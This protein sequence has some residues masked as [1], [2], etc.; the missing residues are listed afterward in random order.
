M[1][2][3]RNPRRATKSDG[4]AASAGPR[5]GKSPRAP[6]RSKSDWKRRHPRA[7]ASRPHALP[8]GAAQH[9]AIR[10]PATLPAATAWARRKRS[11]GAIAGRPGWR[12][13]P[14]LCQ[15]C[16]GGTPALPGGLPHS[17]RRLRRRALPMTDRELK[18]MA[19][20]AIMGFRKRPKSGKRRPAATG[21]PSRL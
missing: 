20:A 17:G 19:A 15:F 11:P 16:A 21:M 9:P 4:S 5:P 2:K 13:R 1:A 14:R 6:S 18:V 10:H 12:R 3:K 8:F 7:R